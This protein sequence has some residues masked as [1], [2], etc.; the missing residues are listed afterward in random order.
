MS[1]TLTWRRRGKWPSLPTTRGPIKMLWCHFDSSLFHHLSTRWQT[2]SRRVPG[3]SRRSR[4]AV[5]PRTKGPR[6]EEGHRG[7]PS[8]GRLPGCECDLE[9]ACAVYTG[10][11]EGCASAGRRTSLAWR[12]RSRC[13][14]TPLS[15]SHSPSSSGCSGACDGLGKINASS[16]ACREIELVYSDPET[17]R[18]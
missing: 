11:L 10:C 3:L 8:P 1:S 7:T 4:V 15:V 5:L 12:S 17:W 13:D 18:A 6:Y 2:G 14:P 16:A 9:M